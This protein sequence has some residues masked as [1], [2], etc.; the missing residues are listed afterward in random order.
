MVRGG[1]PAYFGALRAQPQREICVES[2]LATLT[3]EPGVTVI[4][5]VIDREGD[6][7]SVISKPKVRLYSSRQRVRKRKMAMFR[8]SEPCS[9]NQFVAAVI[10]TWLSQF[11]KIV[12]FFDTRT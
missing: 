7:Q 2:W 11:P 5:L 1:R 10:P 9:E 6:G 12:Y 8:S 3:K 4:R